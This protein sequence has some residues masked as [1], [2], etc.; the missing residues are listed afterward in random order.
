MHRTEKIVFNS[1]IDVK[2]LP[3]GCGLLIRTVGGDGNSFDGVN[4]VDDMQAVCHGFNRI[5]L[6]EVAKTEVK[7]EDGQIAVV[8]I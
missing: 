1:E 8:D 2:N 7:E 4:D 5:T 3:I 6:D